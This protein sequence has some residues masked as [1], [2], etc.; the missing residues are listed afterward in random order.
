[1]CYK[2]GEEIF[3]LLQELWHKG[4]DDR[5]GEDD[6]EDHLKIYEPIEYFRDYNLMLT[7]NT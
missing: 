2:L 1:M 5:R 7:S 6:D 4:F 3:D